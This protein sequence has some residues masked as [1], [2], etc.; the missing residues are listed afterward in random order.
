[1]SRLIVV[2]NRV[3]AAGD[4]GAT[5]G[6][7]AVALHAALEQQGGMW[8]GW[9]GESSG[10]R[11]TDRLTTRESGNI[12]YALADLTRRD[13]D[14]YYSGFANRALWPLFHYRLD[15]TDFS[16]RDMAGYFRVNRY[17]A[18]LLAPLIRPDDVIWVHDYHLIPL[19]AELRQM[20]LRNRMG[21]FLH[22]PWPPPDVLFALPPHETIVR[23]LSSYDLVGFQTEFDAENFA[24]CLIREGLGSRVGSQVFDAYGRLFVMGTFP[25]G[26]ETD[27]FVKMASEYKSNLLVQRTLA[28]LEG[29]RLIIGVD[30]L[31]YSKGLGERIQAFARYV[32]SNPACHGR[33]TL[34]QITPKSRSEVPEYA[35]MQRE[36][37]ELAGRVN[38]ALGDLDWTPIRYIN[39]TVKRQALAGLYRVSRV[40]LVTP[41]RDGMNLV[42]K[43]FVASQ[44]PEDPGVLVLSRFA[45]AA[46]ELDGALLVNPYDTEDI[47]TAI[48]R[49]MDMPLAERQE[50]W[51]PMFDRISK[52]DVMA[53]CTNFLD[54]LRRTRVMAR[55]S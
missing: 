25:I 20:G 30:R 47:A 32:E 41:L 43:E 53:W 9:S 46:R 33:V 17:F 26:I 48:G 40:G 8:F 7:L 23:A 13:L 2:S 44:D 34:L 15:L 1:M 38:G 29:Q 54:T 35:D 27:A 12:T 6:G 19:A 42:A 39:R 50:R 36:V 21:F 14:E 28:S 18:R 24:A 37:A 55:A 11:E 31:D 52:N 16:R 4:G 45:G 49:A 10:D 3:P 5:A 51:Q 22:I